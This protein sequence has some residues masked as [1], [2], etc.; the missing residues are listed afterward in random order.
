MSSRKTSVQVTESDSLITLNI[1]D[2]TRIELTRTPDNCIAGVAGV[3]IAGVQVRA[4][5][6]SGRPW[7]TSVKGVRYDKFLFDGVAVEDDKVVVRTV[8]VAAQG[9]DA[10]YCDEYDGRL[11][12][13]TTRKP[14]NAEV[15]WIF[16]PDSLKLG[17]DVYEGFAYNWRFR[18]AN[19][20]VFRIVSQMT[21]EIGGRATGNTI[22]SQGQVTPAVYTAEP[23]THFTSACLQ[24]LQRFNDPTAM[25][26]QLGPR[27]GVHQCFDFFA[28]KEGSLL[29]MW[30]EKNDT[31]SFIQKN[32]DE[33]V[34]FVFDAE[35]WT[36]SKT[37]VTTPKSILFCPAGAEGMPEHV[38]RNRW[39]EAWEYCTQTVLDI[40]G[41]KRTEPES[42]C[43]LLGFSQK[44]GEDGV[45]RLAMKGKWGDPR[46]WLYAM[47]D[48]YL[49]NIAKQGA[50]RV[51]TQPIVESDPT[52]R[53]NVTKLQAKGLHGDMNIGSVC[54][55]HRY[56][57]AE[58]F[59]GMKAWQYFCE[60]AHKLGLEAGHWI[61]PHLAYSAPILKEHPDWIMKGANTMPWSGGYP[62]FCL[63]TLNWNTPVRQWVLDDLKRMHDEAGLDYVWFDSFANLGLYPFDFSR[64]M[65]TNTFAIMEFI[66][67]LQKAGINGI[68]VEGMAAVAVGAAAVMDHEPGHDGGVQCIAGQNSW[69][70]YEENEDMLIGQQ[71]RTWVYKT[72]TEDDARR[73]HFRCLANRCV[74]NIAKTC[75]KTGEPLKWYVEDLAVYKTVVPV[76]KKRSILPEKRGVQ[77]TDGEKSVLWAFK[78][79]ALDLPGNARVERVTSK[80]A[81]AVD[82]NGGIKAEPWTVY[83]VVRG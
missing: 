32:P 19:D 36:A 60:A 74:P 27:W 52:E 39:G 38:V 14:E 47:A 9:L 51:I 34:F 62:D 2:K 43:D 40:F 15:D 77:W 53:G 67:D 71:P 41:I 35:H 75:K 26:F 11:I 20:E 25:S 1:G 37:V 46:E 50:R 49:P 7:I 83:R 5:T 30:R 23:K 59:G 80:G 3:Q 10:P 65:E 17:D 44:V 48:D 64:K 45:Y 69:S 78:S 54:C 21:W 72:R 24:S 22:L 57:P 55:V 68:A 18:S 73:R 56:R 31:R 29:G 81:E 82:G 63:A 61:G 16:E 79:F 8:A 28:A 66:A 70:W 76:M 33:E 12:M 13:A 58:F 6:I 4:T 42:E